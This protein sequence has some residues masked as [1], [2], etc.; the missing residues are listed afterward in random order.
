LSPPE[1]EN[2]APFEEPWQAKAFA[3][4]VKLCEQGLFTWPEWTRVF[5]ETARRN[6]GATD[7][8]EATLYWRTW[9]AA[10]ERLLVEKGQG[11]PAQLE[12]LTAAWRQAF[13][14]TPHGKPVV[15]PRDALSGV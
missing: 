5:A 6:A 10:L 15:L 3:L 14:T 11:T 8:P 7:V 2:E 12:A 1:R 4:A 13:E 9:V